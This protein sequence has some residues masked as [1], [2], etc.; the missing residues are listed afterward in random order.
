MD[1]NVII[2]SSLFLLVKNKSDVVKKITLF[3]TDYYD[4]EVEIRSSIKEISYTEYWAEFAKNKTEFS[5]VKIMVTSGSVSSL[6]HPFCYNLN[7][8]GV[9]YG[10][11]ITTHPYQFQT[12]I[13]EGNVNFKISDGMK[14]EFQLPGKT[15]IWMSFSQQKEKHS[16]VLATKIVKVENPDFDCKSIEGKM[17]IEKSDESSSKSVT[18]DG[19]HGLKPTP[20]FTIKLFCQNMELAKSKPLPIDDINFMVENYENQLKLFLNYFANPSKWVEKEFENTVG[21]LGFTMNQ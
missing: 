18:I 5:N 12:N 17:T 11:A 7:L 15:E 8:N 1:A 16:R 21:K 2:P 9:L 4:Q 10:N 19:I 14:F 20:S 3:D 6:L 13:I